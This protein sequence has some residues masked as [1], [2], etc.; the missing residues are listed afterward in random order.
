[1]RPAYI[2]WALSILFWISCKPVQYPLVVTKQGNKFLS[3]GAPIDSSIYFFIQPYRQKLDSAMNLEIGFFVKDMV[4]DHGVG[5]LDFWIAN[6][7]YDFAKTIHP[8]VA[9]AIHNSGGIR[10]PVVNAGP[11][12]RSTIFEL[13]PFDNNLVFVSLTGEELRQLIQHTIDKGGWPISRQLSFEVEKGKLKNLSIRQEP[14]ASHKVYIIALQ[15]Y[16]ANGGDDTSFLK[17]KTQEQTG[18]LIRD[19]L[20]SAVPSEKGNNQDQNE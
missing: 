19:I 10:L 8:D 3:H 6:S 9:V 2:L 20:L 4:K 7:I 12:L 11:V 16:I 1:M 13:S 15:D 18:I 14:V 17:G 5:T